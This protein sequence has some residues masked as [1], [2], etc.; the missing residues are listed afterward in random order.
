MNILYGRNQML[1]A[2]LVVLLIATV[3]GTFVAQYFASGHVRYD[4]LCLVASGSW[5]MVVAWYSDI[6]RMYVWSAHLPGLP[7][8]A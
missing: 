2:A 1:L 8:H 6:L 5:I 4:E 3:A 7:A